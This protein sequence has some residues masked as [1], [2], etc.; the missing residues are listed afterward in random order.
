MIRKL[1]RRVFRRG[2]S[3]SV[4][5]PAVIPLARHGIRHQQVSLGARRT[6]E[7][8]QQAGYKAYVVGGAVRDLIAG[9]VPNRCVDCSAAPASSAGASRSCM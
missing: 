8:L 3:S 4:A 9:I 7:T 1:L 5:A 2:D 6:C